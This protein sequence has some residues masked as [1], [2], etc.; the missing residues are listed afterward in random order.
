MEKRQFIVVGVERGGTSIV[1]RILQELGIE[2]PGTFHQPNYETVELAELFRRKKWKQF[3]G[4]IKEYEE[5]FDSFAWKLPDSNRQLNKVHRCFSNPAYIFVFRDI[6][7]TSA[8]KADAGGYDLNESMWSVLLGY[9]RIVRFRKKLNLASQHFS[10]SYEKLLVEKEKTLEEIANFCGIELSET[11]INRLTRIIEP[12]PE[13]YRDWCDISREQRVLG[14]NGFSGA[15][16][17]LNESYICGWVACENSNAPLEISVFIN[18]KEVAQGCCDGIRSDLIAR[19]KSE[20]GQAG[21]KISLIEYAPK[22]GD[23]VMVA[24]KGLKTG[25]S[26][27]FK[28]P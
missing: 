3:K 1:A 10:I 14:Q 16:D 2:I 9:S 11:K 20:T 7:A 23:L 24:P 22:A 28:Q 4:L 18:Q 21:F 12:S 19:K 25:L 26:M 13:Q 8:R 17:E 27:V 5:N 15:I 6:Y